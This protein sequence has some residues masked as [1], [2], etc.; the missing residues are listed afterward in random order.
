[1]NDPLIY[2]MFQ[3]LR[4]AHTTMLETLNQMISR[5]DNLKKLTD[6]SKELEEFSRQI[7]KAVPRTSSLPRKRIAICVAILFVLSTI[8]MYLCF[9]RASPAQNTKDE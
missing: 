5:G 6:N 4:T 7:V 2:Q 8:I 3:D 9:L 1:M